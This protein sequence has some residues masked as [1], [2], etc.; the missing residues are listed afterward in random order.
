MNTTGGARLRRLTASW[1]LL[2]TC[3]VIARPSQHAYALDV[4]KLQTKA[5][6][7]YVDQQLKLGEAYLT[8]NGLP[9]SAANA[10]YW[11]EKAA[12]SGNAE[13]AN[14]VGYMYQAGVGVPADPARAIRWF[15]LSAGSGCSNALIN[16]GILHMMGIGVP[17]DPARAAEYFRRALAHGN[18]TGAAYLGIMAYFGIGTEKDSKA[19]EHWFKTGQ[20]LDDPI[21]TYDLGSFYSSAPEHPS[22][23]AKAAKYLRMAADANYLPAMQSLGILLIHHPELARDRN[24]A[25]RRLQAAADN[26]SWQASLVLGVMAHTGTGT[27]VDNKAAYFHLRLAMLQG[28]T[29][30]QKLTE[31]H[32]NGV[33]SM[34]EEQQARAIE[35]EAVAWFQQH[36]AAPV[37]VR[38]KGQSPRFFADPFL[39]GSQDILNASLPFENP[40][41]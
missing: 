32:I 39:Q 6:Q 11:Y 9:Q 4:N 27:A 38:T 17:K 28:G 29:A 22:E 25:T 36:S 18:G 16:L 30:A 3:I 13:A 35:A 12:N 2:S 34:L 26:G 21:S 31:S 1:L 19:A 33:V 40:A 15:E 23:P 20:K 37:L 41:S 10:E 5:R 14:L 8:G 7:G 24:E